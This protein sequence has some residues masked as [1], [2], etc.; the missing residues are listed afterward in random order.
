MLLDLPE[1]V[2]IYLCNYLSPVCMHKLEYCCKFFYNLSPSLGIWE[3]FSNFLK[4]KKIKKYNY[5]QCVL[6]ALHKLC[7]DCLINKGRKNFFFSIR[8]CKKCISD[9]KYKLIC[10]STAKKKYLL[11]DKE[12][13]QL[14]YY[15]LNNPHYTKAPSMILY[16]EI[17]VENKSNDKYNNNIN[18]EIIKREK[19]MNL[20][21]DNKTIR[22]QQREKHIYQLLKKYNLDNYK[23]DLDVI[24]YIEGDFKD[25]RSKKKIKNV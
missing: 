17:E 8:L 23:S 19:I 13:S 12:L 16:R 18:D 24:L 2:I 10:K 21:K 25:I 6:K 22:K 15:E 14:K 20:R 4:L 5:R 1:D 9:Y 11:N 7:H 3:K